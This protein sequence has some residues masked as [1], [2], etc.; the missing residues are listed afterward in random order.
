MKQETILTFIATRQM[1][2][3]KGPL[4]DFRLGQKKNGD[5]VL[6]RAFQVTSYSEDNVPSTTIEWEEIPTVDID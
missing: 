2:T 3:I 6:Q 5:L 4:P 1:P